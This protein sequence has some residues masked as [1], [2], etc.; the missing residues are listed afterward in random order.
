VHAPDAFLGRGGSI[1]LEYPHSFICRPRRQQTM[2]EPVHQQQ[3]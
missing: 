2:T 1:Y 3:L